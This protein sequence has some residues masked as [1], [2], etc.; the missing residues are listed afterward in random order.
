MT[1]MKNRRDSKQWRIYNHQVILIIHW[2]HNEEDEEEKVEAKVE[3]EVI[4]EA[5]KKT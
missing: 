5:E 1:E 2:K 3:A 4:V